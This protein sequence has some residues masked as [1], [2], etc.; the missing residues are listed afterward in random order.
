MSKGLIF[1]IVAIALIFPAGAGI[2]S[3]RASAAGANKKELRVVEK[4]D[5]GRYLGDWFT[6]ARIPNPWSG[7]CAGGYPLN[8]TLS[9]DGDINVLNRCYLK[10]G[11][12][13]NVR[14]RAWVTDTKTNAKLKVTFF[15]PFSWKLF[16]AKYYI[17]DLGEN[18]EYV[19]VGHPNRKVAW[20]NARTTSLPDEVMRGIIE[21]LED[22]GYDY[23]KFEKVD[24]TTYE[25]KEGK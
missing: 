4:V 9:E 24:W 11:S 18:Y 5:L 8:Y 17:I 16:A 10:D 25:E 14:G 20:I 6:I 23:D 22:Q 1:L 7:R 21:R 2:F 3:S 13:W 12:V 15:P 19:V